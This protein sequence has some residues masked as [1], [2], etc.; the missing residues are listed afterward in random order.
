MAGIHFQPPEKFDFKQPDEWPRWL[1]RFEQF[2]VASG[3]SAESQMRQVNTLLYCLGEEGEDLLHS[4]NITED[5]RR[6][7][8]VSEKSSTDSFK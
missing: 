5:K 2:R 1:K 8:L 3:L 6:N 7:I 4:T